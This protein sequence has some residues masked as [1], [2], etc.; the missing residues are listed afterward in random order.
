MVAGN[1]LIAKKFEK[2]KD[3]DSFIIF[4]SGV[5]NSKS[6]DSEEYERETTLLQKYTDQYPDKT[7]VYFSTCSINDP[8]ESQSDYIAHKRQTEQYIRTRVKRFIIFRV[9]NLV[10]RSSNPNTILNFVV[11]H[12]KGGINFTLWMQAGRNLIDVDDF[13]AI[14][15]H[16]IQ[17]GQFVNQTVNVANPNNYSIKEIVTAAEAHLQKKAHY[18]P[19]DKGSDTSID[20]SGIAQIVSEL[21]ISF[22]EAYLPNLLHKYY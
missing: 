14:A 10:G 20:I 8:A 12:I 19:I 21:N 11:H 1:G 5:S 7:L 16:I 22:T 18:I 13:Y 4:A 17:D 3:N 6:T 15:D 2:Y 9:S